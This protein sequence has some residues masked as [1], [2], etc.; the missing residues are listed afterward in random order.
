MGNGGD[1]GPRLGSQRVNPSRGKGNV[2]LNEPIASTDA[3]HTRVVA[4]DYATAVR[5]LQ[6]R[7]GSDWTVVQ[8][9]KVRRPGLFGWFGVSDVVVII[10]SEEPMFFQPPEKNGVS[11]SGKLAPLAREVSRV[12]ESEPIPELVPVVSGNFETSQE[13]GT[14]VYRLEGARS[15]IAEELKAYSKSSASQPSSKSPPR[16]PFTPT[17]EYLHE[18]EEGTHPGPVVSFEDGASMAVDDPAFIGAVT[19]ATLAWL[20]KQRVGR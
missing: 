14:L 11:S 4:P 9:R 10:R 3:G 16:E 18:V 2:L 7:F 19:A 5:I 13:T 12:P 17:V 6:D 8:S 20:F 1:R 15:K